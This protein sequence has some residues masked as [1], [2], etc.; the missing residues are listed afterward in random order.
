M[1]SNPSGG[2]P[3]ADDA[4]DN[5]DDSLLPPP[6]SRAADPK[7]WLI[8]AGAC[9]LVLAVSWLAGVKALAPMQEGRDGGVV[10]A[11]MGFAQRLAGLARTLVFLP[12][13]S[14]AIVFG[15]LAMAFLN[16]RPLGD[17]PALFARC[18]AIASIGMLVWLAPVEIRFL[19]QTINVLGPPLV[20]GILAMPIFRI[21]PRDAAML[22]G[23][24]VLG[25]L[26]LTLAASVVVWAVG[27]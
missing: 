17:I 13:A 8:V 24:S 1:T 4:V 25:L 14:C 11:D 22:T 18:A 15:T 2:Q 26:I 7:L 9:T 5:D 3:A 19:K 6:I 10:F 20:A 16:Q 21:K 12:L 23:F 27:A